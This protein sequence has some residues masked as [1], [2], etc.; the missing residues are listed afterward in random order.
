M[1][2]GL[3][4]TY[5]SNF[6]NGEVCYQVYRRRT[7]AEPLHCGNMEFAEGIFGSAAEAKA[8]ADKLNR[9]EEGHEGH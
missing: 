2:N 5:I 4:W 9:E 1:S 8:L 6:V 7:M 3:E